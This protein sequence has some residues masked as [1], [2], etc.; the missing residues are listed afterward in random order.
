MFEVARS[1]CLYSEKYLQ[2]SNRFDNH[3]KHKIIKT[4]FS[5]ISVYEGQV[6]LRQF[7]K[8]GHYVMITQLCT[9]TVTCVHL[10][11]KM[12][13]RHINLNLYLTSMVHSVSKRCPRIP[14]QFSTPFESSFRTFL[15]RCENFKVSSFC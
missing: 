12:N 2:I 13:N 3:V 7:K 8:N 14:V 1:S 4:R 15:V 9:R 6:Y 10:Y 11:L 5:L